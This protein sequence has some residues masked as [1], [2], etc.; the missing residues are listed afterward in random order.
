[1]KAKE[2]KKYRKK[3]IVIEAYQTEEELQIE[4]LEGTMKASQGDYV[5]TGVNGEIYPCKPDIFEKTY[6]DADAKCKSD[7]Y[8]V[9]QKERDCFGSYT[10]LISIHDNSDD[11]RERKEELDREN[12]C[13]SVDN[14]YYEHWVEYRILERGDN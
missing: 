12:P 6:E 5:I 13:C 2:V 7:L 14:L 3:P 9:W 8:L 11:A 4:T 1:M 10:E